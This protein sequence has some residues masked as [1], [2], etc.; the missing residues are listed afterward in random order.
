MDWLSAWFEDFFGAVSDDIQSLFDGMNEVTASIDSL[1]QNLNTYIEFSTYYIYLSGVI[2]TILFCMG[3]AILG[4]QKKIKE[5]NC[6]IL[7]LLGS[8]EE[9][10]LNG[11]NDKRSDSGDNGSS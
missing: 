8:K 10:D 3:C 4:N 7:K 2:L 11:G 5:Q 9:G 1:I 6:D